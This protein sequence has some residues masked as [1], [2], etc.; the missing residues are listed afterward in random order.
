MVVR[1]SPSGYWLGI[2]CS[3]AMSRCRSTQLLCAALVKQCGLV[4][5]GGR[6]R[7]TPGCAVKC[8][9][10]V[11]SDWLS[12]THYPWELCVVSVKKMSG[13]WLMTNL[14]CLLVVVLPPTLAHALS[15]HRSLS[16]TVAD[17]AHSFHGQSQAFSEHLQNSG[18]YRN[19]SL[20]TAKDKSYI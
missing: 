12:V 15:A 7:F 6:I 17:V 8:C 20:N 3:V 11:D 14:V 16:P 1:Y 18:M 4:V 19:H 2:Q 9:T 5:T 13:N 10:T